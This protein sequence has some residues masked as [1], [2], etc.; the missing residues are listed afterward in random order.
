MVANIASVDR[1]VTPP[2]AC[3]MLSYFSM[4]RV[5]SL[6]FIQNEKALFSF[7]AHAVMATFAVNTRRMQ[8]RLTLFYGEVFMRQKVIRPIPWAL[9]KWTLIQTVPQ[10]C[11]Q[12]LRF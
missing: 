2:G 8:T 1:K 4:R 11:I 9:A 12:Y 7:D 5:I 10:A 6:S 3:D